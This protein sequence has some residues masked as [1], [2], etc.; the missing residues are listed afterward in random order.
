MWEGTFQAKE[1]VFQKHEKTMYLD[2]GDKNHVA[3]VKV[4]WN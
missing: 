1:A 2:T 3:G 4:F